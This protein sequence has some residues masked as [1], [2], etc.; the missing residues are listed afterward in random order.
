MVCNKDEYFV[1][2][3]P[4]VDNSSSIIGLVHNGRLDVIFPSASMAIFWA[5]N[6]DTLVL[7]PGTFYETINFNGKPVC[8]RSTDPNDPNV[9]AAT[10]IDANGVG[11]GRHSTTRKVRVPCLTV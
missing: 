9:V 11:T 3:D 7:Q 5:T 2:W 8:L 6:N 4:T 10:I 1:H